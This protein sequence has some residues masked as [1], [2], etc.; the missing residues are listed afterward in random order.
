MHGILIGILFILIINSTGFNIYINAKI[1]QA[2]IVNRVSLND[3]SDLPVHSSINISSDDDFSQFS[4]SGTLDNPFVI[5]GLN[6]TTNDTYGIYIVNTSKYFVIQNCYIHADETAIY[7]GNIAS[8]TGKIINNTC[9]HNSYG[10]Y[11]KN[12]RETVIV[13]NTYIKNSLD[14]FL[15]NSRSTKINNNTCINAK[16]ISIFIID[17]RFSRL[18]N[19]TL[20]N[21]GIKILDLNEYYS[22]YLLK[23][24]TVNGKQIGYFVSQQNIIIDKPNYGQLMFINCTNVEIQ[25]QIISNISIGIYIENSRN[26]TLYN[27]TC[28]NNND[29]G[30]SL[31]N[32]SHSTIINNICSY[33]GYS[34]IYLELSNSSIIENNTCSYN[35]MYGI[36]VYIGNIMIINNNTTHNFRGIKILFA[37][38]AIVSNNTCSYNYGGIIIYDSNNAK[39]SNNL[40]SYGNTGIELWDSN[41]SIIDSNF[42]SYNKMNSIIIDDSENSTITNNICAHNYNGIYVFTSKISILANNTLIDEGIYIYDSYDNYFKYIVENNT[43]NGK[44]L[45]YFVNKQDLIID[46]PNYGQLIFINCTNVEIRNQILSNTSIG[47]YGYYSNNF[48]IFNNTFTNNKYGIYLIYSEYSTI[49]NNVISYNDWD[50]LYLINITFSVISNNICSNNKM[51]GMN[52]WNLYDSHIFNN[53]CDYNKKDGTKIYDSINTTIIHNTV[54]NN[55]YIGISHLYS[56]N[57]IFKEN[58]LLNNTK[59][60]VA[61]QSSK[62]CTLYHNIFINNNIESNTSQAYDDSTDNFWYNATL[63]EGNY[64][65]D[66]NW[67]DNKIYR[68]DGAHSR[69]K[70]RVFDMDKDNL[71]ETLEILV[72]HTNP[73]S[74]DTDNDSMPDNWE[75]L[76]ELNPSNSLDAN[77]DAD[78]DGLINLYEY[79]YGTNPLN[80]DTDGD[81]FLDGWEISNGLDPLNPYDGIRGILIEYGLLMF[82]VFTSISAVILIQIILKRRRKNFNSQITISI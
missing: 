51:N 78:K 30:I 55:Y 14:I 39:I 38:S 54:A 1:S 9:A 77:Q 79:Q 27:N 16:W 62:N 76:Y 73:F 22:T 25:N 28:V 29:I 41:N 66:W 64:W 69:D 42:C 10:T 68:I 61:L 75:V 20:L 49:A 11:I 33:N 40:C 15:Y 5:E 17:S 63:K 52:L 74:N 67:F 19:N 81:G 82:L 8:G 48:T 7:I 35:R 47:I 44:L 72:Y 18:T 53:T 12:S 24:N 31:F 34:G 57:T 59:Y 45:G 23:N 43:V 3:I 13:N 26:I 80:P 4:G 50:G 2:S 37:D 60:G 6:I 32:S 36:Y 58:I 71:N 56:K 21:A 70:Y 65:S 46:K